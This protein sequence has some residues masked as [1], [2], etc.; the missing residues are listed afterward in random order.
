MLASC[1]G[2]R[3]QIIIHNPC[4]L[5]S[6]HFAFLGWKIYPAFLGWKELILGPPRGQFRSGINY[7]L[8][9]LI[10]V[11]T[12]LMNWAIIVS[13]NGLSPVWCQ[14]I[15]WTS[16]NFSSTTSQGTGLFTN[17]QFS[18]TKL[19]LKLSSV[20]SSP[21]WPGPGLKK[22]KKKPSYQYRKSYWG[23]KTILVRRHLFIKS[24][25]RGRWVHSLRA[26]DAYNYIYVS[27]T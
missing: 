7:H 3:K 22:K 6:L 27:V 19:P 13:D 11:L 14:A 18:L 26:G 8:T 2:I 9:H 4:W 17:N 23:E 20:I 12:I 16:D 1:H 24:G 10:L 25:P 21:S 5:S 15:I